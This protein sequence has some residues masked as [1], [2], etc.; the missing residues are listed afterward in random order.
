MFEEYTMIPSPFGEISIVWQTQPRFVIKH[1][2]LSSPIMSSETKA[3]KM[4]RHAKLGTATSIIKH[5]KAIQRFL[6]GHPVEFDLTVLD[7]SQCSTIQKRV[8]HAEAEIPRGCISTYGRIANHLKIR[9]G[10]RVVGGSLARNPFPLFIPC[11][12]AIMTDGSLGG[13]QGGLKMKRTLLEHE[14]IQFTHRGK[15][16]MN[17]VYY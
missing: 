3:L 1:I 6:D 11:H 15:V 5:V 14:G 16:I 13:Y 8:L 10:A 2:F 12:R 4:F 9:N 7:W 17:N